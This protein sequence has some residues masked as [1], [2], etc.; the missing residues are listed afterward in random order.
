[1]RVLAVIHSTTFGGAH[2]QILRLHKRLSL[3]GFETLV[4]LPVHNGDADERLTEAGVKVLCL[5][6]HHLRATPNPLSQIRFLAGL[7]PEIQQIRILLRDQNI[8]LVQAHGP[9]NPQAAVAARLE[10]LPIV[11]QLLDTRAPMF[12]RRGCMPIVTRLAHVVMSTGRSVARAHP[13]TDSLGDRLIT[14]VPPVEW[15]R[16]SWTWAD[17]QAARDRLMASPDD[18]VVGAVGNLNPQKGFDL[19]LEACWL[20]RKQ[21]PHLLLR[22]RGAASPN[23]QPYDARLL[24]R[25]SMLGFDDWSIDRVPSG[26]EVRDILPGFDILVSSSMPRSEGLPT[27][28]LEGMAAGLP[29]VATDVGGTSELVSNGVTGFVVEPQDPVAIANAILLLARDPGLRKGMGRAAQRKL[30]EEWPIE[31]CVEAYLGAYRAAIARHQFLRTRKD[32]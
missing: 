2:N 7:W 22:I 16:F 6:L 20:A 9:T 13:G 21:D 26:S 14:F 24:K 1:M 3:K 31:N 12:L 18:F 11:W 32:L 27:V 8:D 17:R 4:L 25:A 5:P 10:N 28:I 19:L 23:H 30:L 15:Q 29:V